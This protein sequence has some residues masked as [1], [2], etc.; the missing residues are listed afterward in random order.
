RPNT[1]VY[2]GQ[3]SFSGFARTDY[4]QAGLNMESE[5]AYPGSPSFKNP[6]NGNSSAPNIRSALFTLPSWRIG[7]D[8]DALIKA[9]LITQRNVPWIANFN[10][11]G[12]A[13]LNDAPGTG[14][15]AYY[16]TNPTGVPGNS[17][18]GQMLSSRDFATLVAHYRLRGANS[19]NLFDSGV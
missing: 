17:G 2:S 18:I 15:Y 10:N 7:R 3:H 9:C 16:W 6:A 12:N 11:W 5:E 8:S 4:D 13:C 14:G 1:Y 19:F